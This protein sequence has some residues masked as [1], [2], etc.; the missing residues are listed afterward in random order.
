MASKPDLSKGLV[1][2]FWL[3]DDD[4]HKVPGRL[5]LAEG[6]SPRVELDE[7]LTPLLREGNRQEHPDGTV[8]RTLLPADVG[9]DRESL[10]VHGTLH[11]GGLV[12]LVDAFTAERK[13]TLPPDAGQDRQ[14]LQARFALLGGHVR[15]QDQGYT[16]IR[17]QL[18]HLD[19]WAALPGFALESADRCQGGATLTF[20]P[21]DLTPVPLAGGGCLGLDQETS[22]EF[23]QVL[24][25]GIH[26]MVWLRAFDLP[27]MTAD[28]LDRRFVTPLSSLLTLAT[29]T[30]CPPVAV[31]VAT[32]AD[33]QWLAVHHSGLRSRAGEVR[34]TH[35]QLLPLAALGLHRVANWL[36]AGE[37]LGPLPP[38]VAAAAAGPGRT[39]E[40]QLLELTTVAEGLH[41]RVFP[42]SRRCSTEKATAARQA[43]RTAVVD[44]VDEKLGAAVRGLLEHLED[45]GYPQRLQ[46]LADYVETAMPGVTGQTKRWKACVTEMR[47]DFAHRSY[48][49]LETPRVLELLAVLRSLR[50]LLTGLL[51]RQTE[52]PPEELA[53]RIEY[54]Q[55]YMLFR[56]QAKEWLPRVFQV[57]SDQY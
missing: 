44:A 16:Q 34:L 33:D 51:L 13:H 35:E 11:D 24:G 32:G 12:T 8:E 10:I 20:E 29:G 55:P 36:D 43:A 6:A 18:R 42:D 17:L 28:E 45:P 49:F 19:A 25:G 38:V 7:P 4:Q 3:A 14:Y 48:G 54:H 47:N 56:R 23:S 37:R 39:L 15:G 2:G 52:L 9:P 53:A 21:S 1:G 26:R 57:P 40:T 30:E 22:I 46:E 5:T 50:W 41:R 31:A 27:S